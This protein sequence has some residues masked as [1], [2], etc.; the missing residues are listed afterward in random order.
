[1]EA[2]SGKNNIL[3]KES[4]WDPFVDCFKFFKSKTLFTTVRN[5]SSELVFT[6][7]W[8]LSRPCNSCQGRNVGLAGWYHAIYIFI[9]GWAGGWH[10]G[11][12]AGS[13]SPIDGYR[14][15]Q[16]RVTTGKCIGEEAD[17]RGLETRVV[18]YPVLV[19]FFKFQMFKFWHT[20]FRPL[21]SMLTEP[22]VAGATKSREAR[23][24]KGY[25][26]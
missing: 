4:W 7:L 3:R 16:A 21:G 11:F 15:G 24:L 26:F 14:E 12:S 17:K 20:W 22:G 5:C 18:N 13:S 2:G 19:G 10:F 1:M 6:G 8:C 25:S 23:M 9:I